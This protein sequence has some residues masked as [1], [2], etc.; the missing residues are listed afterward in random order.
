MKGLEAEKWRTSRD[1][2][3]PLSS[4]GTAVVAGYSSHRLLI[5]ETSSKIV[6]FDSEVFLS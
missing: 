5:H 4:F 1:V 3:R 2:F 6:F